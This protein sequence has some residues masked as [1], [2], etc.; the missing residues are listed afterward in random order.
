M[1]VGYPEGLFACARLS[2]RTNYGAICGWVASRNPNRVTHMAR[3]IAA[4]G[5]LQ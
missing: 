4:I 1:G 5:V 3:G 2:L